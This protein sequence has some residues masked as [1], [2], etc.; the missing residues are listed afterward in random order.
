[1]AKSVAATPALPRAAATFQTSVC[2]L[3][4]LAAG[5]PLRAADSPTRPRITGISHIALYAHDLERSRA[6][7]KEFLGFDEPFSLTNST[8]GLLLTWIKINNR[9]TI[10]LFPE[11]EAG[12]DRLN[13]IALETEDAEGLRKYLATREV[14]VPEKT[15]KGRI[16]NLNF[17]VTDPDG[18]T[19]EMVQ[20]LPDGWT[21]RERDKFLPDTRISTHLTHVGIL[22]GNLDAALHFYRDILGGQET[23]RGGGNPRRLSWVN[24]KVP[25]GDDYIEFMLYSDLP[26]PGKRGTQ[27]HL[28]LGVPEVEKAKTLLESRAA[29]INYARP[30]QIATGVNRK[31]QLNV[32]DPD[33]TRVELMEPHTVDGLPAPSSTALPPAAGG[34]DGAGLSP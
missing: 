9:Q 20:Y 10:E 32:W 13:H 12:A 33:G 21:L 26:E 30:L 19:V 17:N 6:F 18:H 7:Y 28:C 34:S 22:V 14:A 11:K 24:V 8:G 5:V 23:W 2:W 16:G 3:I 27:H 1:M 31:R 29:R 15:V 4:I 25:E